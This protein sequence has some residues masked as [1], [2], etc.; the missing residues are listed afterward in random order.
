MFLS[1]FFFGGGDGQIWINY[2]LLRPINYWIMNNRSFVS[3]VHVRWRCCK[4]K[5]KWVSLQWSNQNHCSRTSLGGVSV[6]K[7]IFFS[8]ALSVLHITASSSLHIILPTPPPKKDLLKLPLWREIRRE[9]LSSGLMHC[10][11]WQSAWYCGEQQSS[12]EWVE[13]QR[14]SSRLPQIFVPTCAIICECAGLISFAPEV[15]FCHPPF[16]HHWFSPPPSPHPPVTFLCDSV[17]FQSP[18]CSDAT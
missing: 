17:T 2:E 3:L 9:G 7:L 12:C 15:T 14:T 16:F 10:G 18:G 8:G 13:E 1:H 6:W 11:Y 4:R 5:M